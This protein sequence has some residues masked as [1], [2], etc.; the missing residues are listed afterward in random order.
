MIMQNGYRP[1]GWLGI[2]NGA[3]LQIDFSQLSFDDAFNLLIREIEAIR[4]SLG[5]DAMD[6]TGRITKIKFPWKQKL[7]L[8]FVQ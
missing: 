2:I 6:E 7:S 8:S 1:S 5:A 4:V 3:K